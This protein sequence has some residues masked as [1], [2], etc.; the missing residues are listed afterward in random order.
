M[1]IREIRQEDVEKNSALVKNTLKKSLYKEYPEFTI[2][3]LCI[4][5]E[6]NGFHQFNERLI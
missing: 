3:K 1:E 6:P 5:Y 2:Q 4:E